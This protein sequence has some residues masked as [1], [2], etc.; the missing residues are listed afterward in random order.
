[1]RKRRDIKIDL[2]VQYTPLPPDR[3][4]AWI[5]GARILLDLLRER[6]EIRNKNPPQ[7]IEVN[8]NNEPSPPLQEMTAQIERHED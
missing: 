4:H 2:K 1:M 6:R 3:V 7:S 5:Y 8:T